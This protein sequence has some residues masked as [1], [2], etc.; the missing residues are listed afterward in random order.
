VG[1]GSPSDILTSENLERA[2]HVRSE[3]VSV[4]VGSSFLVFHRLMPHASDSVSVR[5]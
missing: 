5:K 2:F 4:G 1:V 3:A